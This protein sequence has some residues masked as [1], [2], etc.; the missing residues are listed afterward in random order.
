MIL[1]SFLFTPF[2]SS[3]R[4]GHD[5]SRPAFQ[6]EK[7]YKNIEAKFKLIKKVS[8]IEDAKKII[9]EI[10]RIKKWANDIELE[11]MR[12]EYNNGTTS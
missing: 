5:K 9:D 10:W 2:R 3:G 6:E 1:Q 11:L 7:L 12:R 8:K 4:A